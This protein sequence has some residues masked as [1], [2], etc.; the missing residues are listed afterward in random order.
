LGGKEP[1]T[2]EGKK[3][4]VYRGPGALSLPGHSAQPYKEGETGCPLGAGRKKKKA[5]TPP[6]LQVSRSHPPGRRKKKKKGDPALLRKKK[7]KY[8]EP[9][10][11]ELVNQKPFDERRKKKGRENR[12]P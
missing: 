6:N 10:L 9:S 3:S 11:Q 1:P 12:L 8:A 4:D 2:T 5:F 7:K